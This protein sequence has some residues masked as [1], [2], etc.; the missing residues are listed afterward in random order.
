VVLKFVVGWVVGFIHLVILQLQLNPTQLLGP[1]QTKMQSR[2]KIKGQH[3][4][5]K[6]KTAAVGSDFEAAKLNI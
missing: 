5:T 4:S 3:K 2:F 1:L 6:V